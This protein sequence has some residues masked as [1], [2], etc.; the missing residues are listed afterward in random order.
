MMV[1]MA[2]QHA[3]LACEVGCGFFKLKWLKSSFL[4]LIQPWAEG[5]SQ[6]KKKVKV[7]AAANS[8]QNPCNS[9]RNAA[10]QCGQAQQHSRLNR[11]ARDSASQSL[12]LSC[13]RLH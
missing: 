12:Q 13:K 3:M 8:H 6:R 11:T 2:A 5:L 7:L 1:I 9:R 10:F 4:L